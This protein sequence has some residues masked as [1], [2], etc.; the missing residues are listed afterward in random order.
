MRGEGSEI[1]LAGSGR[2]AMSSTRGRSDSPSFT[3]RHRGRDPDFT[4]L[5]FAAM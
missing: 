1:R 3:R 4:T 2:H 5:R